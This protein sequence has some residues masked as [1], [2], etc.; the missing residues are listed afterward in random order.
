MLYGSGTGGYNLGLL[1]LLGRYYLVPQHA[2]SDIRR[3]ANGDIHCERAPVDELFQQPGTLSKKYLTLHA[4]ELWV[5]TLVAQ[6]TMATIG[7]RVLVAPTNILA[8]DLLAATTT[9][10]VKYN[11]F[12]NVTGSI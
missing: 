7:G 11:N 1:M 12:V 2:G 3:R 9:I 10:T 6:N 5:E 8:T 4:A